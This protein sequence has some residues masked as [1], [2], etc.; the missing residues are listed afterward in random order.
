MPSCN[1]KGFEQLCS[2]TK[3]SI[4]SSVVDAGQTGQLYQQEQ[5]GCC[6]YYSLTLWCLMSKSGF[7]QQIPPSSPLKPFSLKKSD[8]QILDTGLWK[9]LST[10][11]DVPAFLQSQVALT[12]IARPFNRFNGQFN[13]KNNWKL[14][15][16]PSPLMVLAA[17]VLFIC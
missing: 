5:G 4:P 10:I 13:K 3:E 7:N 9:H 8:W 17:T 6:I 14:L 16:M 12:I 15:N 2:L 11:L 1:V